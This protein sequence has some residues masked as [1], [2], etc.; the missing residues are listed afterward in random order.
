MLLLFGEDGKSEILGLC[1]VP[2]HE[3]GHTSLALIRTDN[4]LTVWFIPTIAT[5]QKYTLKCAHC[6]KVS[7]VSSERAQELIYSL[8]PAPPEWIQP[9]GSPGSDQLRA[10]RVRP[11][12]GSAPSPPGTRPANPR[13]PAP[14]PT[15][16]PPTRPAPGA[17]AHPGAQRPTTCRQCAKPVPPGA[18][19]CDRC[20]TPMRSLRR[21]SRCGRTQTT[22]AHCTQCG[23]ALQG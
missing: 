4:K 5:S 10:T 13:P 23:D 1:D 16:P 3:C 12:G 17:S 8:R 22:G 2:C 21:C 18:R 19:F 6:R 9:S 15:S 7:D 14:R 20:G 11:A